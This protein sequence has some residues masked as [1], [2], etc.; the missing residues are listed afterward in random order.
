MHPAG[1]VPPSTDVSIP[2]HQLL[3]SSESSGSSGHLRTE[4]LCVDADRQM[5]CRPLCTIATCSPP[6]S[7]LR[8]FSS[9]IALHAAPQALSMADALYGGNLPAVRLETTWQ[10]VAITKEMRLRA[11]QTQPSITSRSE[12]YP[13]IKGGVGVGQERQV[14]GGHPVVQGK[15]ALHRAVLSERVDWHVWAVV[16]QQCGHV[17]LQTCRRAVLWY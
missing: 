11:E 9:S 10:Q 12:Q 15:A 16:A 2:L 1:I 17:A 7:S 13:P 14:D 4:M 6:V 3:H 5:G 8:R